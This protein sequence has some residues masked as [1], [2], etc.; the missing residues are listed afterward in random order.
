MSVLNQ[1]QLGVTYYDKGALNEE[2]V[3]EYHAS[4]SVL[5]LPNQQLSQ[6]AYK[7][8]YK[9]AVIHPLNTPLKIDVYF[10]E[11]LS[12]AFLRN[13]CNIQ[14]L[15]LPEMPLISNTGPIE[16]VS[17]WFSE[18]EL[19]FRIEKSYGTTVSCHTEFKPTLY[20]FAANRIFCPRRAS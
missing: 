10:F 16:A 4:N 11:Y 15:N 2:Q 9:E 19:L 6:T 3:I 1:I 18:Q 20:S 5:I 17:R 7:I 8:A 13:C 12:S 14:V